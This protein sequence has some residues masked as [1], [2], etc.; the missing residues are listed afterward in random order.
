MSVSSNIFLFHVHKEAMSAAVR[1][2]NEDWPEAKIS[3]ILE[4]GLFEWVR[5]TGGV[6]S[7]MHKA[8]DTLT[9]YAVSRGAEGILYSC[10][11]FGECIDACIEKYDLP[12]LKPNDAMIEKAL[13]YGSKIAIVATVAATIPT[14][15]TEI[16][17]IAANQKIPVEFSS[18]VVDGAFDALAEGNPEKH[19]NLVA[20]QVSIISDCDVI[21]L[22]QFTL[23]RSAPIL[24]EVTNIPVL[25]SPSAA[26]AK[27]R[28]LLNY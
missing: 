28:Y 2:F 4:D 25:N 20:K 22:A 16:Q 21:V 8:F 17:S 15:A 26:V 13:E 18:Y 24:K 9:E 5:E 27:M 6:V 11:A 1:A 10:S 7:E 12:L 14:I 23:S 3:N 19:D